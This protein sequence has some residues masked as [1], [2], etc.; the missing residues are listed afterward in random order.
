MRVYYSSLEDW[1]Q[2]REDK[3]T[4]KYWEL[5]EAD[6]VLS[7]YEEY[8]KK[9]N[10]RESEYGERPSNNGLG[11]GNPAFAFDTKLAKY[12]RLKSCE[13]VDGKIT[14]IRYEDLPK[15]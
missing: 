10:F 9:W 13:I 14:D 1:K 8:Q 6:H 7:P 11:L 3:K 15:H 4:E 5:Q 2:R 12:I